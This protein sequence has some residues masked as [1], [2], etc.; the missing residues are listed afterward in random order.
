MDP[1]ILAR[2][3]DRRRVGGFLSHTSIVAREYGIP[4]V[5]S[6]DSA[7]FAIPQGAQVVVDGFAGTVTVLEDGRAD[8]PSDETGAIG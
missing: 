1:A 7:M 4:A 8:S 6:V 3:C 2:R 5:V